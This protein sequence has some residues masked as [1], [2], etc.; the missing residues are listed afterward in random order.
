MRTLAAATILC[1]LSMSLVGCGGDSA[2][3]PRGISVSISPSSVN[4]AT[5]QSRLFNATVNNDDSG[6]GVTWSLTGTG[7]SGVECGSLTAAT[8]TSVIYTAPDTLPVPAGVALTATANADKS[9]TAAATVSL[10][11][12]GAISIAISPSS[13]TVDLG[14]TVQLIASVSN[15]PNNGGVIWSIEAPSNSCSVFGCGEL[16]PKATN[17]GEPTIYSA[18]GAAF[19]PLTLNVIATSMSDPASSGSVILHVA[20]VGSGCIP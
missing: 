16:S 20:C 6:K 2:S 9:R 14:A 7:C 18:P 4:V 17:S 1:I 5:S 10:F 11:E 3:V 13:P 12:G 8:A 19:G 15:D